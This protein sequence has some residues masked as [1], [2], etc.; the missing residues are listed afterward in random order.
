MGLRGKQMKVY[1]QNSD[2]ED[3][4]SEHQ[5]EINVPSLRRYD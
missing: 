5:P 4:F 3:T 2:E 1:H